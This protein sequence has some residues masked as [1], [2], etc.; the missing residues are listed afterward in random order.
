MPDTEQVIR[1]DFLPAM[2]SSIKVELGKKHLNSIYKAS[3]EKKNRHLPQRRRC[4][5]FV[6]LTQELP[7]YAI[8]LMLSFQN[9][10]PP[11]SARLIAPRLTCDHRL[12]GSDQPSIRASSSP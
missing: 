10:L 2:L 1:G 9:N 11:C 5:F 3:Q 12:Y 7:G 4:R 6:S 8:A